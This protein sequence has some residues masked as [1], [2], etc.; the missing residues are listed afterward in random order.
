MSFSFVYHAIYQSLLNN[1]QNKTKQNKLK[2]VK[3]NKK[4]EIFLSRNETIH[5]KYDFSA[6]FIYAIIF[7]LFSFL[8]F[9]ILLVSIHRNKTIKHKL[10]WFLRQTQFVLTFLMWNNYHFVKYKTKEE[11]EVTNNNNKTTTKICKMRQTELKY[12]REYNE[13]VLTDTL[14]FQ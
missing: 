3:E 14:L 7:T 11:E 2:K 12:R 4:S 10:M 8:F 1:Q 9:V 5:W 13:K 6:Q